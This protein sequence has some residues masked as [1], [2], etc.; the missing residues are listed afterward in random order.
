MEWLLFGKDSTREVRLVGVFPL[1]LSPSEASQVY[2]VFRGE[3]TVWPIISKA[4]FSTQE[5]LTDKNQE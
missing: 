5:I 4:V 3:K 2:S 1:L